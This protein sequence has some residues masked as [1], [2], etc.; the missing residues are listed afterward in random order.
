MLDVKS[1]PFLITVLPVLYGMFRFLW[2]AEV[3]GTLSD[4]PTDIIFQD[5]PMQASV[6]IFV[7]LVI[8]IFTLRLTSY[9]SILFSISQ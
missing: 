9:A 7:L 3:K 6:V 1:I 2:L 5:F 8:S 4:N